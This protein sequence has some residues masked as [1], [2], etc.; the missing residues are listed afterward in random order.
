[1]KKIVSILL[2]VLCLTAGNMS[3]LACTGAEGSAASGQYDYVEAFTDKG[4]AVVHTGGKEGVID[5]E[6]REIIAPEWDGVV[7]DDDGRKALCINYPEG[8]MAV[9][10]LNTAEAYH[11][12]E[13]LPAAY[14]SDRYALQ[15]NVRVYTRGEFVGLEDAD[16]NALCEA[17]YDYIEAFR[18]LD[19]A[20]AH[21][22]DKCGVISRDGR[23]IVPVQWNYIKLSPDGKTALCDSYS[24]SGKCIFSLETGEM[25]YE[26]TEYTWIEM[27]YGNIII[28]RT[29]TPYQA[30]VYDSRMQMLFSVSAQLRHYETYYLAEFND[31]SQG[32]IDLEGN[33]VIDGLSQIGYLRDGYA[34]YFRSEYTYADET[35]QLIDEIGNGLDRLLWK[36]RGDYRDRNCLEWVLYRLGVKTQPRMEKK[37][38]GVIGVDGEQFEYDS[39]YQ[40]GAWG[41]YPSDAIEIGGEGLYLVNMA[42]SDDGMS[43]SRWVYLDADGRQAVP[44]RY[45]S[46]YMFVDG[47]AV[48]YNDGEYYLI[49]RD[50]E[51]LCDVADLSCWGHGMV[52]DKEQHLIAQ[53]Y[54][55]EYH[56]LINRKGE[57]VNDVKY[58]TL[59][60][61]IDGYF[62]AEILNGGAM[63][64]DDQ[65]NAVVD[66]GWELYGEG[67]F[68]G[69]PGAWLW[70][71]G[72]LYH[73]DLA[74]GEATHAQG[75]TDVNARA[76]CLPD[77]KTWVVYDERGNPV[78][79]WYEQENAF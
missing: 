76:A 66:S 75:Y 22:D 42:A 32:M 30:N 68:D 25:L 1:M 37:Y 28:Q 43:D 64:L 67:S 26:E 78:G 69:V 27:E 33:I 77:G 44:G 65:G 17:K 23:E 71:D 6:G 39:A 8:P 10:D 52:R 62:S 38:L 56:R 7:I 48:V 74:T 70:K 49:D 79:P 40:K 55:G 20:I 51:K 12:E 31:G 3:S 24:N 63:I 58:R 41:D 29:R 18:G 46:A 5:A 60:Y 13:N 47:G 57:F 53:C 21:M 45:D 59:Q 54:G 34:A 35:E 61:E 36:N 16:G 50:G 72:L 73:V 14:V 19:C 15:G 2:A 11:Q 9:V 4:F